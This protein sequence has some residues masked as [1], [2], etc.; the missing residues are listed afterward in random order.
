MIKKNLI[1]LF[2]FI[3]QIVFSQSNDDSL[4]TL[5]PK[6]IFRIMLIGPIFPDDETTAIIA[7][8]YEYGI[9]NNLTF[10]GTLGLGVAVDDFG[11][12]GN[13]YQTSY[14]IYG[15]V[16]LKH[17]FLMKN[18]I[19]KLRPILKYSGPYIGVEQNVFTNPIALINQTLKKAMKGSTIMFFNIGYQKQVSK[20]CIAAHF[21]VNVWGTYLSTNPGSLN[22]LH[23][24]V[25]IGYVFR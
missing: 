6:N 21:G 2:F 5:L 3:P 1:A 25:S 22:A 15:S 4:K 23:G 16:Q 7:G 24:A 13:P 10:S 9:I 18:R 8:N 20:A 14:H 17:F 12:A 19:R 11:S